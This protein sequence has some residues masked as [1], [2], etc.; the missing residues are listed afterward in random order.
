MFNIFAAGCRAAMYEET[1]V[2]QTKKT[3]QKLVNFL[4]KPG[5]GLFRVNGFPVKQD[6]KIL[7]F[8]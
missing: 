2:C 1:A 6:S 7:N 8:L 3:M 4:H 5:I